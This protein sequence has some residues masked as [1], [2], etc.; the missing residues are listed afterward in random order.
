[1]HELRQK[2]KANTRYR[3]RPC[4]QF[5]EDGFCSYGYRCQYLHNI[6]QYKISQNNFEDM[7]MTE[8]NTATECDLVTS[9][10]KYLEKP[11]RLPL[12]EHLFLHTE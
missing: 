1:M 10:G 8:I 12:F 9:I 3:T 6:G 5:I 7:I 4:K 11:D 2:F